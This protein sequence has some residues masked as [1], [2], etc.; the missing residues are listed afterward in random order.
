[1]LSEAKRRETT[2][3][4]RL[5][6]EIGGTKLQA[7]VGTAERKIVRFARARSLASRCRIVPA[8]LLDEN[9]VVGALLLDPCA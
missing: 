8:E 7:A 6:I 2:P 1:M 5:A 3:R 9:V 4:M